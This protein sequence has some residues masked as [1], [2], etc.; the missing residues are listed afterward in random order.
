[1]RTARFVLL[2]SIC[3]SICEDAVSQASFFLHNYAPGL[4][5]DAPVYDW[6]GGLLAGSMWRVE[7]YGGAERDSLSPVLDVDEVRRAP[8]SLSRPG[9]FFSPSGSLTVL[10]VPGYGWA[11]LQVRV[12]DVRLGVTFEEARALSLGGYGQ[13]EPFYAQGGASNV[14]PPGSPGFLVGLTSFSVLEPVPEPAVG[15]LVLAG[16][17]VWGLRKGRKRKAGG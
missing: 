8:I 10:S 2:L 11:W 15:W 12:W 13:S 14:Q 9:Y 4:G 16:G 1:M 17:A 7:L 6:S 5:I 3:L